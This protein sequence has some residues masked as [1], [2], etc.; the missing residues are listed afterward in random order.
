M[1]FVFTG[2]NC[3]L[4][5]VIFKSL[6]MESVAYMLAF[7]LGNLAMAFIVFSDDRSDM[8]RWIVIICYGV[9]YLSVSIGIAYTLNCW[10]LL[11]VYGYEII[12][13]LVMIL[14]FRLLHKR[15]RLK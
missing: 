9:I 1:L 7:G 2:L 14:G 6:D 5:F 8:V 10:E 12:A 15:E 13:M 4:P 11:I 3:I